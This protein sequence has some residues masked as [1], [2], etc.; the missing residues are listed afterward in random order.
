MAV[1]ITTITG[2]V[3]TPDGLAVVKGTVSARLS[4]PGSVLDGTDSQR[5]A[6]TAKATVGADGSIALSLVPN[7]ALTP[8][9]TFYNVE[10]KVGVGGKEAKWSEKWQITGTAPLD[11]GEVPRLGVVPGIAVTTAA[12]VSESVVASAESARDGAVAA[13]SAAAG[14]AGAA[15]ATAAQV[16]AAAPVIERRTT[17]TARAV[18]ASLPVAARNRARPIPEALAP[19]ISTASFT[20]PLWLSNDA[21]TVYGAAATQL[22]QSGDDAGTWTNLRLFD[23]NVIGVR[24]MLNGEM[25][26]AT[27]EIG[28]ASDLWV[29]SGYP[30]LGAACTWTKVLTASASTSYFESHWGMSV[31]GGN[32]VVVSEYGTKIPTAPTAPRYVYLS[33]DYGLTWRVGLD[34]GNAENSHVHGC[35]YDPWWDRIW[36]A[37]GD[38]GT[39]QGIRY[40][41]D[42]GATWTRVATDRQPVG[43]L[44]MESCI[45][46]TSDGPPNGI[47]R[48]RRT[49][50]L[51]APTVETAHALDGLAVLS[52]LGAQ[53]FRLPNSP[54]APALLPFNNSG[55]SGDQPGLLLLTYDGID[56]WEVWRDSIGYGNGF[57]L[58]RALGPTASGKIVGTLADGRQSS[59]S[60]F[61]VTAPARRDNTLP[62]HA[63]FVRAGVYIGPEVVQKT[64]NTTMAQGNALVCPVVIPKRTAIDRIGIVLA[65]AGDASSLLRF[66]IYH[67]DADG[68]PGELML[69]AG[70]VA[71]NATGLREVTVSAVLQP[72]VYWFCA[73]SQNVTSAPVATGY[74]ALGQHGAVNA[75]FAINYAAG[76][77][78]GAGVTGALPATFPALAMLGGGV[79]VLARV[80]SV[81]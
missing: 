37:I 48:I 74:F 66:G 49:S 43:I 41:D 57:G 39:E 79:A 45:L 65:T 11:L 78:Y 71:A 73:V 53:A 16:T 6:E 76:A 35:A 28:V 10:F 61:I 40:S 64:I 70:T 12:A 59:A 55:V 9:G 32:R 17:Y 46:F 69:D 34:I 52:H 47:W 44:P 68:Y 24:Q 80:A 21:A 33:E 72:G 2:K 15:Q 13:A 54:D 75:T 22:K 14:D 51:E 19:A 25:L 36:V 67:A 63:R 42:L 4:Q 26:V 23:R 8:S 30:T 77:Y 20:Y 60:K 5:V 31:A 56:F 81:G 18:S 7:D 1:P 50:R 38:A 3:L 62:P 58:V 29:S 27:H